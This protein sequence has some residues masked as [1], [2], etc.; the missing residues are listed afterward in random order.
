[1]SKS[2]PLNKG[3]FFVPPKWRRDRPAGS[4]NLLA[5]DRRSRACSL[6]N[7]IGSE[8]RLG[9]SLDDGAQLLRNLSLFSK[10]FTRAF[11][12]RAGLSHF[13]YS[14]SGD[15]GRFQAPISCSWLISVPDVRESSGGEQ[16]RSQKHEQ[17]D[18]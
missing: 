18:R 8:N 3:E 5:A 4:S 10:S 1:M 16:N 6:C 14:I 7:M 17:N 9:T 15:I 12:L 13:P 11:S 2:E